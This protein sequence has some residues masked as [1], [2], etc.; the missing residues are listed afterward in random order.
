[1]FTIILMLY[2][3]QNREVTLESSALRGSYSSKRECESAATR[4]RG[5]LPVPRGYAAS[6]QDAVCVPIQRNAR[7]NELKPVNLAA[8]LREQPAQGC[9]G[10]GT[11][12]RLAESCQPSKGK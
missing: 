5:P 6:W 4:L 3:Q 11:W 2:L 7:V 9:Q 12:Q 1:M 10:D 8:L